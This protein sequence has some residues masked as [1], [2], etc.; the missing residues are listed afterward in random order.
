MSPEEQELEELRS[1]LSGH[2]RAGSTEEPPAHL[3]AAILATARS[4]V[5]RFRFARNWQLPVSIAAV[6]VIGV[7]L[8]LMTSEIDDPLPPPDTSAGVSAAKSEQDVTSRTRKRE[9]QAEH[10]PRSGV[11]REE[12]PSRER[13]ARRD[14]ELV[15]QNSAAEHADSAA[16]VSSVVAPAAAP[17]LQQFEAGA[18]PESAAE[19][20]SMVADSAQGQRATGAL[21]KKAAP[22]SDA[23][24]SAPEE[25]L[26]NIE[27]LLRNGKT[28][29]AREQLVAFRKRHP[30]Y[31]LPEALR[32][33]EITEKK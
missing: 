30:D 6:F 27:D 2:Y 16:G 23:P 15:R 7:S 13:T 11:E 31:R 19:Q 1:A 24:A 25:W 9:S 17:A 10:L 4:E 14:R 12:R 5:R 28:V 29:Q 33:L 8:A 26:K 21:S 32:E 3:D 22:S 18:P 20:K